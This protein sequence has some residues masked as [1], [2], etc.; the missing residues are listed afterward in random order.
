MRTQVRRK[1]RGNGEEEKGRGWPWEGFR[2][3]EDQRRTRMS[4]GRTE[5]AGQGE[6]REFKKCSLFS[7]AGFGDSF[8]LPT[9]EVNTAPHLIRKVV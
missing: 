7:S 4:W 1:R 8:P 6:D 3:Q 2:G 9:W 5:V